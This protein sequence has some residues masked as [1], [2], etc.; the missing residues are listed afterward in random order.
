[1]KIRLIVPAAGSGERLGA[2][3]PKALVPLAGIPLL[4]HT[5]RRF[6]ALG[7][8]HDAIVLHAPEA[9]PR[10]AAALNGAL[11]Q[12]DIVLTEGGATRQASVAIG[13]DHADGADIVVIHDAAR[14]FITSQAIQ[15][16]IDAAAE[17]GAATVAIPASDTILVA[18][19]AGYL[20]TTPDRSRLWCCQTPQT[21][22]RDV[23][24][25][26][27]ATAAREGYAGTD[28]ATLVRRAGGQV[29]LIP[30]TS[31]NLKITT[32]ADLT[33]AETIVKEH[34]A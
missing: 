1:M 2:A 16:S 4:V 27:H 9:R 3:C 24:R 31:L 23:I 28:D 30:G 8:A 13:L 32:P 14:P 12:Q 10:F 25:D 33:L 5:L 29:K 6:E 26:A 7:L 17:C 15:A 21:F 34:L 18:D 11:A 20:D 19:N 22:R